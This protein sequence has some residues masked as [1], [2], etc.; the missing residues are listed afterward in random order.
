MWSATKHT[1]CLRPA[2]EKLLRG[3]QNLSMIRSKKKPRKHSLEKN[4]NKL[5]ININLTQVL[6]Y[7]LNKP[8]GLKIEQIIQLLHSMQ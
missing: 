8:Q 5:D 7:V 4:K 2:P 3:E 1:D 6:L